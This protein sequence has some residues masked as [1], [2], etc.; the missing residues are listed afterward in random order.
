MSC[1]SL[2]LQ[3]AAACTDVTTA[4]PWEITGQQM[5]DQPPP[6]GICEYEL[7]P[8]ESGYTDWM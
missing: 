4:L 6:A 7:L 3:D 2:N 1:D 5:T 8:D